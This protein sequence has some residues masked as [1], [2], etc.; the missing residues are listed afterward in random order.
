MRDA[1][2]AGRRLASRLELPDPW[3]IEDLCGSVAARRGRPIIILERPGHDD[4]ITATLLST[5]VADYV[6]CR[7]DLRGGHREHAI[8]HEIGHL[9]IRDAALAGTAPNTDDALPTN[10]ILE[11][12]HGSGDEERL[13][14][15]FADELMERVSRRMAGQDGG[16]HRQRV[17]NGFSHALR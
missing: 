11:L 8:C 4:S 5:V 17:I 12:G 2:R 7:S 15:S 16:R 1:A 6:F 14:E 13:A 3:S 9:L 10:R